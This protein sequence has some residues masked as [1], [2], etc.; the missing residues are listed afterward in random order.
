V[1][2]PLGVQEFGCWKIWASTAK[3]SAELR[4]KEW[5]MR[6]KEVGI[7]KVSW[8]RQFLHL[9]NMARKLSIMATARPNN[10]VV[11]EVDGG[12]QFD[13]IR[14]GQYAEGILFLRIP[15]IVIVSA[16]LR[17]KTMHMLGLPASQFAF[18][19][20]DSD[21][22]STRCPTYW[23]PT[24]RVDVRAT[25]LSMLWVRLDQI[26][27]RRRDRKGVVHTISYA[28]RD[29]VVNRSRY[30]STMLVNQ[31]GESVTAVVDA[32][33]RSAPGTILVSPSIG[34]GYDFPGRDCE[35]QFLCKIPF[36]DGRSKINQ[37]RQEADREYGAYQAMQTMVQS[38]GRGMR[39]REDLCEN[40]ICDDHLEWFLPKYRHLAPKSFHTHF[41]R[42]DV[43]PQPPT[44][45]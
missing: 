22:D 43:V 41:R 30:A 3:E 7:P 17:P 5:D 10:W 34:T 40:F 18:C 20:F 39:S 45:L 19:E 23:V 21:F 4:M 12:F 44:A 1:D 9:K 14:P 27:S 13:C 11:E 33:K 26:A 38:F 31:R 42:A 35:W 37:A 28:R 25:D 29:D 16:T 2:Y 15:K 32:F 24:M 6:M 36:P 8:V